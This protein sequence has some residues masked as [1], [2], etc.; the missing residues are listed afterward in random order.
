MNRKELLKR[1]I[2]SEFYSLTASDRRLLKLF[3][4]YIGVK[5]KRE[6]KKEKKDA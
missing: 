6:K 5:G 3:F 4:G 2:T 1:E